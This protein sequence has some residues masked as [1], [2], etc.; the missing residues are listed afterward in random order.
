[1]ESLKVDLENTEF[2]SLA[3]LAGRIATLLDN[4]VATSNTELFSALDDFL[5]AVYALIFARRGGFKERRDQAPE[6]EPPR[7]RA[8]Q[9]EKGE[10]RVDGAWM[11]GFHFNSALYRLAAVYHR[12]LKL[13]ASSQC[14]QQK[15]RPMVSDLL[16]D[17]ESRFANWTG[18][19]WVHPHLSAVHNEVNLLKHE[20]EGIYTTRGIGFNEGVSAAEEL[21]Q[22]LEAWISVTFQ[23]KQLSS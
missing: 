12:V 16:R 11:A 4:P 21:L 15:K 10:V 3:H 8:R 17:V 6:H 19:A 7:T 9:L 18:R 13:A 1:M 23:A 14:L 5:G 2:R 20:R 22:L